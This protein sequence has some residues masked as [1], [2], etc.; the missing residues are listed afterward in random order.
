VQPEQDVLPLAG[1]GRP[2]RDPGDDGDHRSGP[3]H[4][5]APRRSRFAAAIEQPTTAAP[6]I[7]AMIANPTKNRM[8]CAISGVQKTLGG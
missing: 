6:K 1:Q 8:M 3:E 5:A 2:A 7:T 4:D